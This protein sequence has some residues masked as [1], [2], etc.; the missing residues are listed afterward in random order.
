MRNFKIIILFYFAFV[1]A[2]A[3]KAQNSKNTFVGIF[4]GYNH[5]SVGGTLVEKDRPFNASYRLS[6]KQ[7]GGDGFLVYAA[8]K[9][10]FSN[11]VYFKYG[12]GYFQKQ[13][14]PEE[15]SY[16]LYKDKLKTGYIFLPVLAGLVLSLNNAAGIN[17]ECG[18][19]VNFKLVDKSSTG[20]DRVDFKTKPTVISAVAGAG[21]SFHTNKKTIVSFNY[22]YVSDL[23]EA[24]VEYLYWSSA[25]PHKPFNYKYKTHTVTIGLQWEL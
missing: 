14:N 21:I 24:Y 20:P 3:A 23:T 9:H 2:V 5:S 15:N 12:L 1:F 10:E 4:G 19:A 13:V 17:I 18:P 25:E 6:G 8:M 16:E 22:Q 11:I 7:E